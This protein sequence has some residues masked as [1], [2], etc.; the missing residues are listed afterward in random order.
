M[1]FPAI[2]AALSV[3]AFSTLAP[4]AHAHE[5]ADAMADAA[6]NFL[7]ALDAE[8]R[9]KTV[10]KM[11]A[12]ER[13]DWHFIP[14]PF[15]GEGVRTGL[16]MK[17]MRQDQR[18]LGFA[19]LSSGLS[20]RGFSQAVTIMSLEQVLWE[21]E[22]KA[23]KRNPEMYY[24][25]IYG[26]P[27]SKAWGWRVEGHHLSVHFTIVDGKVAGTPNF[28]ATNPG[29]IREGPRKGLQV[30]ADEENIARELVNSLDK[31]QMQK[32]V[33]SDK[34]PRDI[35]TSAETEVEPLENEGVLAGELTDGQQATL[36]QLIEVYVRRV[37]PSVADAD[38]KKIED[39]GFDKIHFAWAGGLKKGEGHYYRVQGPTFLLEYANTQNDANHVHAVW[40][41]FK[42][43]FGNDLLR[44]HFKAEHKAPKAAAQ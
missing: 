8:Q 24:I 16:P 26:K 17:E 15:E 1:K 9:K 41:D 31:E 44:A 21:L 27:G 18:A 19:L 10:Y 29:E 42:N 25:T 40:R 34:A 28:F 14:K 38:L 30:L 20:H 2:L 35:L 36:Q 39:A 13:K 5:A 4:S 11:D 37:R 22:N 12:D 32:A 3:L 43:D 33:F 7:N 6:N 23:P